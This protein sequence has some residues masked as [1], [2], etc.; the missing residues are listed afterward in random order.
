[1]NQ[2]DGKFLTNLPAHRGIISVY[3]GDDQFEARLSLQGF[4][5][6][7]AYDTTSVTL[8]AYLT[9][10][11]DATY[12]LSKTFSLWL[13]GDNLLGQSYQVQPGYLEPQFHVR[14]GIEVIF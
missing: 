11:I 1:L 14:S 3:R 13:N 12:H 5:D 10:G 7:Q 8:P 9:A 4:S 6:R 2:T